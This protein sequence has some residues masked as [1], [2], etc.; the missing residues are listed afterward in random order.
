MGLIAQSEDSIEDIIKGRKA[1]FSDNY[2][3]AKRVNIF[4]NDLEFEEAK[5]FMKEMAENYETL[6]NYFPENTK[7]GFN[8]EALPSIWENKDEFNALMQKSA[9]DMKQLAA[10]IEDADD[11]RGTMQQYMWSNCKACHSRF[12]K[13]H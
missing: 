7:E 11:L 12:R 8:T 4:I 1:I 2:K 6:L 10:V 13:P 5:K 3:T 9:D